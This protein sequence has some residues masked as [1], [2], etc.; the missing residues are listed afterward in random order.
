MSCQIEFVDINHLNNKVDPSNNLGNVN[1]K[2]FMSKYLVTNEQFV[3]FLNNV[4]DN[5]FKKMNC[6]DE[7]CGIGWDQKKFYIK[8]GFNKKPIA[9]IDPIISRSFCNYLYN[10]ENNLHLSLETCYNQESNNRLL[11]HGYFIP[12]LNEWHKAA[13]FNGE[14]YNDYP[15][16]NNLNPIYCQATND[17]HLLPNIVNFNNSFDYMGYNG[18]ISD[19]G[20][21]GSH[22][23]YKI[24]DMAGNLY[25]LIIDEHTY[26]A[27]GSWHS[28]RTSL[29]KGMYFRYDG[30]KFFGSTIGLR[31]IKI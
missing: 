13:F 9:F 16:E 31:I 24:Y 30:Y 27:G 10:L 12:N 21:V 23:Q 22:S 6:Y 5:H 4:E 2:Y 11:E 7:R 29:S 14:G 28:W 20:T 26:I 18:F 8:N 19:V 17:S 3:D 1:Y 15:I 25:D